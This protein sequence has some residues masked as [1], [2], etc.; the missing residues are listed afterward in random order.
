MLE[1]PGGKM[2]IPVGSLT[3]VMCKITSEKRKSFMTNNEYQ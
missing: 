3:R 2:V 1:T